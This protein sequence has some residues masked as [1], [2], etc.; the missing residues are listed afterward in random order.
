[1]EKEA[2]WEQWT[3]HRNHACRQQ[4]VDFYFP[5]A[6]IV[7]ACSYRLRSHDDIEFDDYLQWACIGLIES[8]DRFDIR[9]GVRFET[10]SEVRMRG[11]IL[12][13]IEKTSEKQQQIGWR[14]RLRMER[15]A[16]LKAD[17]KTARE[18]R[19]AEIPEGDGLLRYLADMGIG[20]ALAYLLEGTGMLG[21][22]AS[23]PAS[24]CQ[25][26]RLEMAQM[27]Q[28][29]KEMVGQLPRQEYLVV[30]SHYLQELS[31]ADIAAMMNLSK[32]RV[33]QLHRQALL[34]LREMLAQRQ[35]LDTTL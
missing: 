9:L 35:V 24:F 21:P 29:L 6:R 14:K 5:H 17:K 16:S 33:A 25:Y 4:L 13:G 28:R 26:R 15:Y 18:G 12:T 23:E 1:M 22:A 2:L 34:R 11:A 8:I 3:M 19:L 27:R 20:L 31:F 32:G 10:F 30:S 7:A